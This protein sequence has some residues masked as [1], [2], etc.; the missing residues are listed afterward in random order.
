MGYQISVKHLINILYKNIENK[1]NI[2]FIYESKVTSIE[3][4][5]IININYMK[6]LTAKNISSKSV[7]FSSGSTD[8]IINKIFKER[9]R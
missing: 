7:I 6:N 2:N 3:Q 1:K 8:N 9:G 5:E 4:G